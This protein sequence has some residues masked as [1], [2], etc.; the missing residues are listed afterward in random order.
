[1]GGPVGAGFETPMRRFEH[2]KLWYLSVRAP[3]DL[4]V[5]YAFRPGEPPDVLTTAKRVQAFHTRTKRDP[6]NP[7]QSMMRSLVE[8]PG[9]PAQALAERKE[10]VP[11]G[12]IL[13]KTIKSEILGEDRKI[14][15]YLPSEFDPAGGPYPYLAVFD[16]EAYGLTPEA[17]IPTPTILDNLI[18]QGKV[19]PMLGVLVASQATREKDLA[20]SA[21]FCDFL[22]EELVPM[23]RRE[24]RASEAPSDAT[25]AGSSF[26]GLAAAY[27]ALHHPDVFGNALS[28]SGSFW[29]SPGAMETEAPYA[30]ETGALMR[31][32]VSAPMKPVRFWMEVG[33][34]EGG[35]ALMGQ[36]QVGQN[37]HM[38]DVLLAKGYD[39]SYHEYSGGHDYASWRG[40]LADGL[41]VLAGK[42]PRPMGDAK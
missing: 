30:I 29:F 1:M 11:A 2:T 17:V 6:W 26:G 10:G 4:R 42:Q 27:C 24:F 35:G 15:V 20:M 19:P 34:F 12:R 23:L 22:A 31:E 38:R 21:P 14:G 13:E 40:S 7:R 18:A 8:L 5:T 36:T 41:I 25:L 39:V 3:K 33:L 16:G 9:A 28:Q 37:R 32:V